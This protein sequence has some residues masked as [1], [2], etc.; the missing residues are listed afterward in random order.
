MPNDNLIVQAGLL[1]SGK[2]RYKTLDPS[3]RSWSSFLFGSVT[4]SR[5]GN[6]TKRFKG[7]SQSYKA[8]AGEHSPSHDTILN[9]VSALG[10]RPEAQ[11]EL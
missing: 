2:L 11:G 10:L 9:V 1:K 4:L 8:F 7:Q 5:D 6:R 3:Q